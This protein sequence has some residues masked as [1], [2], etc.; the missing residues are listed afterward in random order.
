ML[1]QLTAKSLPHVDRGALGAALDGALRQV[2]FDLHDRPTTA[3]KRVVSLRLEFVP[4]P[5]KPGPG[6]PEELDN[7]KLDYRVDLRVPTQRGVPQTLTIPEDAGRPCLQFN[8][9]TPDARQRTLDTEAARNN[10]AAAEPEPD[11]AS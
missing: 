9:Q 7:V 10:P 4:V 11:A 2:L 3:E 5:R 8:D 6:L 1:K